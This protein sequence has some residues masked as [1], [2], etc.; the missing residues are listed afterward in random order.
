MWR[1]FLIY[2]WKY[3]RPKGNFGVT[4]FNNKGQVVQI[5]IQENKSVPAEC[6]V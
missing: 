3:D 1:K 6:Y 5:L 4:F 2:A